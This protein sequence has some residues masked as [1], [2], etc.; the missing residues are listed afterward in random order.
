CPRRPLPPPESPATRSVRR[1]LCGYRPCRAPHASAPRSASPTGTPYATTPPHTPP[2]CSCPAPAPPAAR[3]S[4]TVTRR[5]TARFCRSVAP[6]ASAPCGTVGARPP[7]A[8]R[9]GSPPTPATGQAACRLTSRTRSPEI[10]SSFRVSA[11]AVAVSTDVVRCTPTLSSCQSA[12]PLQ[13]QPSSRH[14][15]QTICTIVQI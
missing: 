6:P 5:P 2:W 15:P 13:Y 10:R 14:L 3:T 9:R 4:R 8:H 11:P 12:P 1:W 7:V